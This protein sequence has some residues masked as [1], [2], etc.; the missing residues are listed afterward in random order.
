MVF[1][2]LLTEEKVEATFIEVNSIETIKKCVMEGIG[3]T[4]IP[5][6]S[7]KQEIAQN[8]LT[9]LSWSQDNL[10][11]GIL[12]I[13]HKDKWLS[14]TLQAFMDTVKEVLKSPEIDK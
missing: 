12:M 5:K 14:P 6:M 13:W 2:Q 3:V 4:L 11:T 7:V 1:E 9:A 10:E 8:T